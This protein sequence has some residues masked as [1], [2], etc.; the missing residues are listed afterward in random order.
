VRLPNGEDAGSTSVFV[1]A[2][3]EERAGVAP[4]AG[5]RSESSMCSSALR[6]LPPRP[7]DANPEFATC[8]RKTTMPPEEP[9]WRTAAQ[10]ADPT[11]ESLAPDTN[12]LLQ[13]PNRVVLASTPSPLFHVPGRADSGPPRRR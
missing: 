2:A 4:T 12:H 13:Q 6:R 3:G 9:K 5:S 7:A 1:T 8:V 10:S 11:D